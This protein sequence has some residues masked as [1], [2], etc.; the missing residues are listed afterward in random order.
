MATQG[1]PK[2]LMAVRI[3]P[4]GTNHTGFLPPQYYV[5]L[6][7]GL[8][9]E[10][11]S[12]FVS[13]VKSIPEGKSAQ[14]ANQKLWKQK[15]QELYDQYTKGIA[16]IDAKIDSKKQRRVQCSINL[17][18]IIAAGIPFHKYNISYKGLHLP[19]EQTSKPRSF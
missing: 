9:V 15:R 18:E 5:N 4:P 8:T 2:P 19:Y 14:L 1:T 11:V 10:N 13:Y 3:R 16:S 6:W 12:P 7:G 17:A